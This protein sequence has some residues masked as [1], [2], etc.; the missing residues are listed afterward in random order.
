MKKIGFLTD[1]ACDLPKELE[2]K[3]NIDIMSFAITLDGESYYERKDFTFEEFYDM[4]RNA[5]GMP[6]TAHITAV[7][8]SE[9]YEQY[10]NDG[11]TDIIHVSICAAGSATYDA[12]IIGENMFREENPDSEL[13]IHHVDSHTYSMCYGFF[14]A[15]AAKKIANGAKVG[16]V[17]IFLQDVFSRVE[18][19]VAPYS[20]KFIKKSGRVSA[21]AA[22]AGELLGLKPIISLIDGAST[23]NTKVRGEAAI[24]PALV[25]HTK[26]KMDEFSTFY[27]VATTDE[28]R[29]KELAKLCKKEL[30]FE[31]NCIFRLGAAIVSNTGPDTIAIVYLGPARHH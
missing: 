4:V 31:A 12:S 17:V 21:A 10:H 6:T 27:M 29:G 14:V 28:T 13:K 18:V 20:L 23:I 24:L 30:G 5:E 26:A 7:Q 25:K 1:S 19:V 16:E 9:K 3:Y 8:F 22:F 15:E 11:Y 2:E